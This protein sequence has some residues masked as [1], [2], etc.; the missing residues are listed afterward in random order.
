MAYEHMLEQALATL[1]REVTQAH[2]LH[3]LT[4]AE[5]LVVLER[6]REMVIGLL[7]QED[8]QPH[9]APSAFGYC[10]ETFAE[11]DR[12]WLLRWSMSD[13]VLRFRRKALEKHNHTREQ[14]LFTASYLPPTPG[15]V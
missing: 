12:G 2:F 4:T 8:A 14:K 11:T 3:E 6:R 9:T 13:L 5:T 1:W 10:L 15:D 7:D